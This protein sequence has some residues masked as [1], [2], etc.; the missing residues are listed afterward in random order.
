VVE[1][2]FVRFDAIYL[3]IDRR[4]GGAGGGMSADRTDGNFAAGIHAVAGVIAPA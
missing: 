4:S 2:R 1:F 3:A